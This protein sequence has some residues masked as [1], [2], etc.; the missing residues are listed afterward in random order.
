[1]G[2]FPFDFNLHKVVV[3][4]SG[5]TCL[6]PPVGYRYYALRISTIILEITFY[7][8]E[9]KGFQCLVQQFLESHEHFLLLNML[10]YIS[11]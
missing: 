4:S 5:D 6:N 1:M 8:I 9:Q 11:Q 10:L 3:I 2:I 7:S